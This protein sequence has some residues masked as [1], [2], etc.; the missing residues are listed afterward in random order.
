[1]AR[2]VNIVHDELVVEFPAMYKDVVKALVVDAME[3][4]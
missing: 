2:V 4:A 3:R 1:M